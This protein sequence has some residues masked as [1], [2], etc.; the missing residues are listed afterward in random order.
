MK[1]DVKFANL[2]LKDIPQTARRMEAL[3]FDGAWSW[4]AGHN[5]FLPLALA[6]EHTQRISLGTAIAVAFPRSPMLT[7]QVAWD[8]AEQSGGRFILGLGTQ[9]KAHIERRFSV[10]WDSP[11]PRMREIIL[12][13]RAI[14]DTWQNGTRLDFRGDFYQFTLSTPFFSPAP[15]AHP[16][17]PIYLAG[18]NPYLCRLAGELAAGLH[19]HPFHSVEYLRQVVLPNVAAGA[20]AAGRPAQQVTLASSLFVASGDSQAQIEAATAEIRSQIAFYASTPTYRI[21]LDCHGWGE[22]GER[23]SQLAREKQWAAMAAQISDEMLAHFAVVAPRD[24]L[25][26]RVKARCAGLLQRVGFYQPFRLGD[27]AEDDWWAQAAETIHA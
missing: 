22:V 13:L 5:P 6:A 24:E 15:I 18:S 14:W 4:E 25:A 9:V 3:G 19:V 2:P 27:P 26:A 12:A 23:L 10:P 11:G 17:V 16:D 8:L 1:F 20:A 21:V 7:A